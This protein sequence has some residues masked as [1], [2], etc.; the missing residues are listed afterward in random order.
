MDEVNVILIIDVLVDNF[1][2]NV[3][4]NFQTIFFLKTILQFI[5]SMHEIIVCV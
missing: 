5:Q 3:Y 1:K 2:Q 4:C